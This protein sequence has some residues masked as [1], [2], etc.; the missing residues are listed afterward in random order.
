[1]VS[2]VMATTV[3]TQP[4]G[5]KQQINMCYNKINI[6]MC[7]TVFPWSG[8][9]NKNATAWAP[10]LLTPGVTI[11]ILDHNYRA[12]ELHQTQTAA[13]ESAPGAGCHQTGGV[14]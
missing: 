4:R 1:M 3:S 7:G 14:S 5:V 12:P 8:A 13:A 9:L 6:K 10:P 11:V 2:I